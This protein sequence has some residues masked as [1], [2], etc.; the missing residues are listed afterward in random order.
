VGVPRVLSAV[1]FSAVY[2]PRLSGPPI[3]TKTVVET[4]CTLTDLGRPLC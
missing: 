1:D 3:A 4:L 2:G